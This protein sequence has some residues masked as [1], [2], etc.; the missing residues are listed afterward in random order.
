MSSFTRQLPMGDN[1]SKAETL[2]QTS[3]PLDQTVSDYCL[4]QAIEMEHLTSREVEP[5][6][7]EA[8]E[9]SFEQRDDP[10]LLRDCKRMRETVTGGEFTTLCSLLTNCTIKFDANFSSSP[11][12]GISLS[13]G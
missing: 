8:V 9:V 1:N 6:Q 12:C 3:S 4:R 11:R 7:G 5:L 13:Q 2:G 10:M